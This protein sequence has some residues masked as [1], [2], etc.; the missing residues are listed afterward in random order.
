[1]TRFVVTRIARLAVTLFV[2]SVAAFAVF[3]LVPSDPA[4][5]SCGQAVSPQCIAETRHLWGLDKPIVT[6]YE[7]FAAGLFAGRWY[8]SPHATDAVYCSAPCFGYSFEQETPVWQLMTQAMPVTFSVA[9]G[10]AV[11]WLLGG[12]SIGVLS[13]VRPGFT[14]RI[15]M[16]GSIVGLS[17]PAFFSGLVLLYLFAGVLHWLPFSGYS[18]LGTPDAAGATHWYYLFSRPET[19]LANLEPWAA[20]LV[21][22]WC[23]LALLFSALYARLTRTTMLDVMAESYIET[24]RAKGLRR[25][26]VVLHHGLRAALMPIVTI[27]GI[28]LGAL[29]GGAILTEKVFSLPGLGALM[30][31]AI[32]NSDLP[33]IIG[34]TMF[35][36]FFIVVANVVVDLGYA[37]LDPRI[38]HD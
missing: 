19:T 17:M 36:A 27:F 2:I 34:I 10:A 30:L 11:L 32:Q 31:R 5:L 14:S 35:S 1:M 4:T 26:R 20:H 29:L 22:P 12:V 13:A 7:E 8:P 15:L 38:R 33:V 18:P 9:L 25:R 24:A 37:F 21:L 28:D 6:Q 3:Y 23:S 16:T